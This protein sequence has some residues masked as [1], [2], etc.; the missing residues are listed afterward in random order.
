MA[1]DEW[2]PTDNERER[3]EDCL[4]PKIQAQPGR[5][6]ETFFFFKEKKEELIVIKGFGN[7]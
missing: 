6:N 2:S 7:I 1:E 5:Q 4:S 3:Q